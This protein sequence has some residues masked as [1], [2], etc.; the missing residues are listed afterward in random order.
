[1]HVGEFLKNRTMSALCGAYS[2]HVKSLN[3]FEANKGNVLRAVAT[4]VEYLDKLPGCKQRGGWA[5][6]GLNESDA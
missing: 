1:M 6:Y 5:D 2:K 3:E 4:A